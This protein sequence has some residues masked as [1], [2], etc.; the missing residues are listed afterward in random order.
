MDIVE[1]KCPN[2]SA[3]LKFNPAKQKLTC[4]Y[5]GGAFTLE[6]IKKL[7]AKNESALGE[8]QAEDE[9]AESQTDGAATA[10]EDGASDNGEFAEETKMWCGNYGNKR[11]DGFVLLLLPQSSNPFGKDDW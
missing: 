6:E 11:A 2:C 1:Y 5:C 3:D 8:E 7:F 4:E 9:T 10:D